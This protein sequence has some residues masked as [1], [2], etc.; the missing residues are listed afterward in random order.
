MQNRSQKRAR[1]GPGFAFAAR[2]SDKNT[3]LVS[4]SAMYGAKLSARHFH[5]LGK[6]SDGAGVRDRAS[7]TVFQL[8]TMGL[9]AHGQ[10]GETVLTTL[11]Q[12]ALADYSRQVHDE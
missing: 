7:M 4:L 1:S 2:P 9:L 8:V 3:A 5:L 6:V 12:S 11:G 10:Q